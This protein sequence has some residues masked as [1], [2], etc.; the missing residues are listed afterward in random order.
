MDFHSLLQ[1]FSPTEQMLNFATKS[2][3]QLITA[4]MPANH[5]NAGHLLLKSLDFSVL[6]LFSVIFFIA[7]PFCIPTMITKRSKKGFKQSFV[8]INFPMN[9]N[10]TDSSMRITRIFRT[11][12]L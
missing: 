12:N 1:S 3:G 11:R 4:L 2:E 6:S 9:S 8:L 10:S 5:G 7:F